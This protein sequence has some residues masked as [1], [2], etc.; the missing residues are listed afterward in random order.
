NVARISL[1]VAPVNDAPMAQD[2]T[3]DGNEGAP[4]SGTLIATDVDSP[5]L[6]YSLFAQ[7]AHGSVLVNADGTYTYTPNADFNGADSF[8]FKA[9]DG[10]LDSNI[11][12]IIL[13][14]DSVNS[15]PVAQD[16]SASGNEDIAVSGML[17]ATDVDGPALTYSLIGQAAHGTVV[18]NPGG[19]YTYT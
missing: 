18:V 5:V 11:A 14:L 9:N 1:A 16:G 2:G 13:T 19:S 3:V 15:A 10:A 17:V 12:T 7:A 6:T 4:I 8:A